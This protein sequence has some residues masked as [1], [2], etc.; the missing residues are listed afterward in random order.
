MDTI[1][2]GEIIYCNLHL[3]QKDGVVKIVKEL[4]LAREWNEPFKIHYLMSNERDAVFLQKHKFT[5]D[6]KVIKLDIISKH[7]F[8]NKNT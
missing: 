5:K 8:K 7:G 3:R 6:A 1:Q 2:P 4:V